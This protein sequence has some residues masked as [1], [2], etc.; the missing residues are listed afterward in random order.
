MVSLKQL[1][2]LVADTMW[3]MVSSHTCPSEPNLIL[4]MAQAG[5]RLVAI[6]T[7]HYLKEI[8]VC[9][10]VCEGHQPGQM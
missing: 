5:G 3:M 8:L 4:M 7:A 10:G 1:A 6:A 2:L 9:C